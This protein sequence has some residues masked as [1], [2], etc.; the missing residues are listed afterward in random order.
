MT[1]ATTLGASSGIG[2]LL[3]QW[4]ERR[5]LSQLELALAAG[6]SARHVSFVETG[7]SRPSETMILRLAD[8]LNVP[9]RDRNTL[10]LAAGYAPAY[11]ET[12]LDSP[13][14]APLRAVLDQLL[15]GHE[16]Y[17]ALV[18]DS[19]YDVIAANRAIA[20]MLD[21]VSG[22]LLRPP[23][24]VI[25]LALHPDGLAG[26]I[27]NFGQVRSHLIERIR[28]HLRIWQSDRLRALFDEVRAYPA[29]DDGNMAAP[30]DEVPFALPLR[31]RVPD[32]ELSFIS[33]VATFNTPLDITV[34]ELG[35][36]TFLPADPQTAKALHGS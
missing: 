36:E 30:D 1:T 32:G 15:N 4:R 25:R 12:P 7:R 34:A 9:M 19:A 28:Q 11:P 8:E 2:P 17:P 3:R 5:R 21:G 33:V 24:N 10:L 29:Q 18:F 35:I 13:A 16:P 14:M 23:M 31:L 27:V 26:R 6:V 20:T 22:E